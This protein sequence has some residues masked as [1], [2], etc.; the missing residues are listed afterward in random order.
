MIE[1]QWIKH[2]GIIYHRWRFNG[3]MWHIEETALSD[4]PFVQTEANH[5]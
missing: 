5:E 1:E 3:G 4:I 2:D